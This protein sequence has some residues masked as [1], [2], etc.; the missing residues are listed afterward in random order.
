MSLTTLPDDIEPQ[1]YDRIE[2][3]VME[4][5]RGRRFLL[6]YGRRQR[7]EEMTRALAA[8]DR[9]EDGLAQIRGAAHAAETPLRERILALAS[10]FRRRGVDEALCA[11][12]GALLDGARAPAASEPTPTATKTEQDYEAISIQAPAAT[13]P[14]LLASPIAEPA[15]ALPW[16]DP[17]EH[18][19]SPNGGS[20]FARAI[21][22]LGESEAP[23]DS[24]EDDD[25]RA[26]DF[27]SA[28]H[29]PTALAAAQENEHENQHERAQAYA[30]EI[31]LEIAHEIAGLSITQQEATLND[32]DAEAWS[33]DDLPSDAEREDAQ[34][35]DDA[36]PMF[37]EQHAEAGAQASS[38]DMVED[39]TAH[40]RLSDASDEPRARVFADP[41]LAALSRL[42][43]LPF[44]EKI[45]LF[46]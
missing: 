13:E 43:D 9:L 8:L 24:D 38:F 7:A 40:E 3:A 37:A 6:E 44:A 30:F 12:I 19:A 41:R 46:S 5:A 20:A 27:V 26:P 39:V 11:E 36:T 23:L 14:L 42:D 1:D 33:R 17:P 31:E 21:V 25:A 2:A 35:D 29:A 28:H 4:T 45:A 32:A 10:A 15:R 34:A 16:P 18:A 22:S